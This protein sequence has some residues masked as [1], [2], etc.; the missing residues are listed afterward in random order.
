MDPEAAA[1]LLGA[2]VGALVG[3]AATFGAAIV[4]LRGTRR[5][6]A[7]LAKEQHRRER[8]NTMA[9][10]SVW[11]DLSEGKLR[12]LNN[13]GEA[14]S[15][16]HVDV[17]LL[18]GSSIEA[19]TI[20]GS[21]IFDIEYVPPVGEAVSRLLPTD[22]L[23]PTEYMNGTAFCTLDVRFQDALGDTWTIGEDRQ[24]AL[25]QSSEEFEDELLTMANAGEFDGD[26]DDEPDQ[27]EAQK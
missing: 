11:A 6:N 12:V 14:I 13:T 10:V 9:R 21:Q 27:I 20:D 24:V 8:R 1:G 2:L 18:R 16:I 25:H 19:T 15:W 5:D 26:E 3:G 23:S 22:W 17:T 7:A 4:T